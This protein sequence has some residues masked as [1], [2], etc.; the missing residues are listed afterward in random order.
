M[1]AYK[2]MKNEDG[3]VLPLVALLLAFV[4]IGFSALV[5]DAG[6]LYSER[7]TMVTAADAAALAGAITMEKALGVSDLGIAKG[8]AEEIAKDF[9]V[10][11]GIKNRN[12]IIV[13]WNNPDFARNTITVTVKNTKDLFFA[14]ILGFDNADVGAKAVATWG[15]VKKLE[16]GDILPVFTKDNDYMTNGVTY[17]HSGKFIGSDGDIINGNWGLIDIFGNTNEIAKAFKGDKVGLKMELD[18][19][20]NNQTGLNV[21]NVNNPIE[22]RMIRANSLENKE[23]RIKYMSGLVPVI[24]WENITKQGSTLKLPIKYFAV[25]EIYDVIIHEGNNNNKLSEGSK[26]ALYDN[27]NYKSDSVAKI[28]EKVDGKDI[29]KSTIIGRFTGATVEVRAVLQPGDQTNPNPGVLSAK[30]SKLIE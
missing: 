25:F 5:V 13:T 21:G 24:D 3:A 15:Y 11:N 4:L 29:E 7:R 20:I 8:D 14:R 28:Y 22:E 1:K 18:Y 6:F 26:Y 10:A 12:D 19:I 27:P 2:F 16:G 17:L 23:D 9:G 30:Y